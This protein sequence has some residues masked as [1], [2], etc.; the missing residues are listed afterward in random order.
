MTRLKKHN[1]LPDADHVMRQV[2]YKLLERD[3][4]TDLVLGFLPGAFAHRPG[5]EYLS[6]GWL[7]YFGGTHA[8][9]AAHCKTAILAVRKDNK[10]L[11]GVAKV[12]RTKTLAQHS[13]K[14][15]RL[16]YHPNDKNQSHSAM[17]MD[18]PVPEAACEDLAREFFKQQ[19]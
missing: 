13:A 9:N 14:P 5:E 3:V 2:P 15:V 10:A 18:Q 4:D 7:E 19:H 6:F 1:P 8:D 11:H 17:F 16:V 12:G